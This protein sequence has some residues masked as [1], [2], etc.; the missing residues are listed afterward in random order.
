MNEIN[1]EVRSDI[2]SNWELKSPKAQRDLVIKKIAIA[3]ILII[4]LGGIAFGLYHL[5]LHYTIP[6]QA[7]IVSPFIVGVLGAI[8]YLKIPS[9]GITKS[10]Y[11]HI[12]T[13]PLSLQGF[14]LIF[15]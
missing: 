2:R 9:F 15:F 13:L 1:I 8:A 12:V 3:I 10:N 5:T 11:T 7:L 6:T 4:N 14:L